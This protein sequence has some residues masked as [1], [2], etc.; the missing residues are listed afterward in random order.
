MRARALVRG[1]A[2]ALS[3]ASAALAQNVGLPGLTP[4][5]AVSATDL[6]P[7]QA[8]TGSTLQSTPVSGLGSVLGPYGYGLY[9]GSITKV[10]G[11]SGYAV[12]DQ[13]TLQC[14]GVTWTTA[15]IVTVLTVSSGGVTGLMPVNVGVSA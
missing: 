8:P 9:A 4:H 3:L 15:P 13:I 7:I 5:G 2:A 12:A 10:S 14:S 1:I 6:L 11:G